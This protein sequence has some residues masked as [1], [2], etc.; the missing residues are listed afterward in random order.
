MSSNHIR[1]RHMA[2]ILL[3]GK[4]KLAIL[5]VLMAAFAVIYVWMIKPA[6]YDWVDAGETTA[7]VETILPNKKVIGP[8]YI[9]ALVTVESGR[10]VLVSLPADPNIQLGSELQLAVKQDS[11]KTEV[12]NYSF[13]RV[14]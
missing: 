10:K 5:G 7:V 13:I 1:E 2:K 9:K 8:T 12:K 14:N 11:V 6:D 3:S 4:E